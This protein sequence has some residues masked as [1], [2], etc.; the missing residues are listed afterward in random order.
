[1]LLLCADGVL[2]Q[3]R[4]TVYWAMLA[5]FG[6]SGNVTQ[7]RAALAQLQSARRDRLAASRALKAQQRDENAAF[8]EYMSSLHVAPARSSDALVR[9]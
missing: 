8:A 4:E 6:V 1:M 3:S 2:L 5:M 9:H 7:A